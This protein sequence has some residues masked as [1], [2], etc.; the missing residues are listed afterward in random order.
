MRN[1]HDTD[2]PGVNNGNISVKVTYLGDDLDIFVES[3]PG[4]FSEQDLCQ[5]VAK[6]NKKFPVS[7]LLGYFKIKDGEG[8][9]V[10]KF[11][12]YLKIQISYSPLAW[13]LAKNNGH[14]R[15]GH[16][17]R[18]GDN[19][20]EEWEEFKNKDDEVI[21]EVNP[22]SDKNPYGHVIIMVKSLPDPLIGDC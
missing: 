17:A 22:P 6:K 4:D 5:A 11:Q 2:L 1:F 18:S 16:I 15:V 3:N 7:H 21:V 14:P 8:N 13:E 12:D 19:W 10:T 20:G 9:L